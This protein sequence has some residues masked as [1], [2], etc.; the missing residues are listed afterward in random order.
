MS[1]H[2]LNR[3]FRGVFLCLVLSCMSGLSA[4]KYQVEVTPLKAAGD[5]GPGFTLMNAVETQ[6]SFRN[7]LDPRKGAA[8]R[9]LFNGSGVAVG[10]WDNDGLPDLFFCGIDSPNHLYRNLGQWKF[11]KVS[12][13]PSLQNPGAP[14]RGAVF[15]DLNG[16]R[17]L[18]LIVSTVGMGVRSFFNQGGLA[19]EDATQK[20]G[21]GSEFGATSMALADVDGNGTLDLYVANYRSNDIRDQARVP[22]RRVRGK[23]MPSEELS[24]RIFIHGGQIHEYGE[25]DI[26][27]LNNGSGKM[28][29]VDW[30]SGAFRENGQALKAAPKDWGLSAM[31]RDLNGDGHVDLYVC[32]DYW[33]PDRIWIND[34]QGGF[35]ALSG[36]AL[37]ITSLSSM[38]VD[39]ADLNRDG[40]VDLFVVDMLSRD[41]V[42][43]KRQQP[44]E[45][46]VGGIPS[47]NG[48][49]LQL[50]YNTLFMGNGKGAFTETSHFAGLEASDWSW[51]PIFMDADLDGMDDVLI[52]AGYPHDMQ[53]SDTLRLIQSRQH[54]WDRYS[55]DAARQKAFTDEMMQH[56]E[57][58][59]KLEMPVVAYRGKGNGTFEEVTHLWGTGKKGIHQG[60]AV[61]DLD[62]D[63]DWDLVL[64]CLNGS[65]RLF[66][67]DASNDRVVIRLKGSPSNTQAIGSKMVINEGKSNSATRSIVSGGRYLSGGDTEQVF[68]MLSSKK[69]ST[70]TVVWP[71]GTSSFLEDLKRNHRYTVHQPEASD[72]LSD[73]VDVPTDQA[74]LIPLFRDAS[75]K[76]SHTS[77][78]AFSD[79]FAKQPLLPYALSHHGPGVICMDVNGDTI[80]DIL[81]GGEKGQHPTLHI[82]KG[83]VEFETKELDFRLINDS[84]GMLGMPVP[85]NR[86]HL[87]LAQTGYETIRQPALMELNLKGQHRS[88]FSNA[89]TGVGPMVAGPLNGQGSLTVFMGGTYISR[90]YPLSHLSQLIHQDANGWRIDSVHED[91]LRS[92]QRSRGAVWSDL[93]GDGFAELIITTEWGL[94]RVLQN[95]RG[96]L[97]DRTHAWGLGAHTGLWGGVVSGDM[98]GNGFPDLIVGNWGRNSDWQATGKSPF[99]M[100]HGDIL[101][102]GVREIIETEYHPQKLITPKRYLSELG[103]QLPFLFKLAGNNARYS[104]L[105]VRELFAHYWESLTALHAS[106][107]D[108]CLFLNSGNGT[109]RQVLLPKEVQWAPVFGLQVGDFNG[110]G[111][112]DVV[113]GQNQSHVREGMPPQ[114]QGRVMILIGKGDGQ[115]NVLNEAE[116]GVEVHGNARGLA[117]A[118][119]NQDA[120]LDFVVTQNE[121]ATKLYLNQSD[122]KQGVRVRLNHTGVNRH[123]I[124]SQL[125]LVDYD[126]SRGPLREVQAG[127]GWYSQNSPVTVLHGKNKARALW[128]KWPGGKVNTYP[129]K[130]DQSEIEAVY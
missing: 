33:T 20:A 64:N 57:L 82:G 51:C 85:G 95:T 79:D 97:E 8:N 127:N 29:P 49:R 122:S 129:L 23:L 88:L 26:L 55:T 46:M 38:G 123:G 58:Y 115:F 4:E 28:T 68:A 13:P 63:G 101:K 111:I 41:P 71:D 128:V 84:S 10:D 104:S 120:R 53:D 92:I 77:R 36:E 54:S 39:G 74:A 66:R 37:N 11:E 91:L 59:P 32:N 124:G 86:I 18:D 42:L 35:D 34:G 110:D 83:D 5:Q 87:F 109:F 126:D 44:A 100:Y 19:F 12:I 47:L 114:N 116:S 72:G 98:D 93:N 112:E 1:F 103:A 99:N 106:T 50:P 27:Y 43:R 118:D 80:T 24:K 76:L 22:V 119:F 89:L 15:A 7:D 105:T 2:V 9:V 96:K 60:F 75:L 52:S 107:L 25:P 61:G 102:T 40:H 108:T 31:F 113:L 65:A 45:S 81:I 70:L 78:S 30:T 121:G 62:G 69:A 3:S 117:V 6:V 94:V 90:Q 56:I 16:D 67:N 125:R 73:L 14:C 48:P 130:S 17:Y 21:T